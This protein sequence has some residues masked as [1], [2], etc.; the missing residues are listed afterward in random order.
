[1]IL[2]LWEETSLKSDVAGPLMEDTVLL[3]RI[4]DDRHWRL[5]AEATHGKP[6][7]DRPTVVGA[8]KHELFLLPNKFVTWA[9]R[10]MA[11]GQMPPRQVQCQQ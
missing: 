6:G 3:S 8:R 5:T 4:E 10:K 2:G 1:M 7:L 11:D 9:H